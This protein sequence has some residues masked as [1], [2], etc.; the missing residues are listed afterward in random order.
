MLPGYQ[1]P[2]GRL[3]GGYSGSRELAAITAARIKEKMRQH[4][5][6]GEQ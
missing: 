3:N 4:N 5:N 1:R 2:L 6:Q